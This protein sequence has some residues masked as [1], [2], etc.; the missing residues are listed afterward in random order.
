[1]PEIA[2]PRRQAADTG[3]IARTVAVLAVIADA[4]AGVRIRELAARLALPAST[5]H[6][7]LE[8]LIGEGMVERDAQAPV[9][10]AGPEFLRMA[11]RVVHAHP[12][13]SIAAPFLDE[14][15]RTTNETAYLCLYLP[16]EHRLSFVTHRESTHP[17][18]YRVRSNEPQSLLVGAS[19]RSILAWLDEPARAAAFAREASHGAPTRSLPGRRALLQDLAAIR[20]RGYALSFGQ[21]IPGAVGLFAPVFAADGQVAGSI[22]YTIPEQRFRR[23][24]EAALSRRIRELAAGL[25]TALGARTDTPQVPRSTRSARTA[26]R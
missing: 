7:L 13:Q 20:A 8:R 3:T 15:V 2:T 6:R 16:A 1:M 25:S 22:G 5:V 23:A 10:R 14:A 11:A 9:Y 18:G 26:S 12:L 4:A 21:R 17:L 19:G 24:S